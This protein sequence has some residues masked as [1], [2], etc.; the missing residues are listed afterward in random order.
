[1]HTAGSGFT[2]ILVKRGC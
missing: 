1:M 2:S